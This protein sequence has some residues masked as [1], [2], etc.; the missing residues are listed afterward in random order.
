MTGKKIQLLQDK[1]KKVSQKVLI[2]NCTSRQLCNYASMFVIT[3]ISRG[4]TPLT[5]NRVLWF[6]GIKLKHLDKIWNP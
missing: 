1:A 3:R 2:C 6:G 5:T 4:Y